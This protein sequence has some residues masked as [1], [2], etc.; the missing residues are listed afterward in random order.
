MIEKKA[1][2]WFDKAH[3]KWHNWR[4]NPVLRLKQAL[5]VLG[6]FVALYVALV[7]ALT[8]RYGINFDTETANTHFT[9]FTPLF[10]I[11][12]AIFYIDGMYEMRRLK[13]GTEFA[14]RLM[15]AIGACAVL[16]LA[17][18]YSL[19]LYGITPKTTLVI[20]IGTAFAALYIWRSTSNALLSLR[21]KGASV[22]MLRETETTR[23]LSRAITENPQLGYRLTKHL[24]EADII[25]APP[26][27][28]TERGTSALYGYAVRGTE[29]IDTVAM[30]EI[31]FSKLPIR[32]LE[33]GWFLKGL[34]QKTAY[35]FV[36]SPIEKLAALTLL[37]TLS[38]LML[39]IAL[40]VK[41]TSKGPAIFKQ[42]RTGFLGTPFTLYKFRSMK[43][44][45]PDG[46]AEGVTGAVWKSANDPRFTRVGRIIERMHLDELPQLWNILKGEVSFVGPRPE[47]PQFVIELARE[48]PYYELRHLVKPGIAGWAQLQY[49]YGASVEDAR[50]KLQYDL[51][52]LKHRSFLMDASIVA[53]TAKLF[54]VK[55][56]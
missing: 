45:A 51:Y 12:I 4:M 43:A 28:N 5:L 41:L 15:G 55:N 38:P 32:D 10:F 34:R 48:I 50:E 27:A 29:I 46:S 13:N 52:Y 26:S 39:V 36:R 1:E 33:E 22:A 18:F 16:S 35:D 31:I 37:L 54:F 42:V 6:D 47:R 19:P 25:V 56:I 23:E 20:F 24:D 44:N 40:A 53:K 2:K 11:W 3:H 49:H 8:L 9:A 21:T 7:V 30:Y 14:K 17:F